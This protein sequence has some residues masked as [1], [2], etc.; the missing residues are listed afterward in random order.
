MHRVQLY[1]WCRLM[2]KK[3]S[4]THDR[5]AHGEARA[6]IPAE[7]AMIGDVSRYFKSACLRAT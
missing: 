6:G 4:G 3:K 2:A 5:H 1:S 7:F